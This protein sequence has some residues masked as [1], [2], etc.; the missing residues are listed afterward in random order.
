MIGG[1]EKAITDIKGAY[2]HAKMKYELLINITGKEVDLFCEIDLSL[3]EFVV[4]KKVPKDD[5]RTA[6]QGTV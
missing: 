4:M 3:E 6:Q 1:R 5:I 2:I